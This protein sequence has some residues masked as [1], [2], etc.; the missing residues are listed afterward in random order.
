MF[1]GKEYEKQVSSLCLSLDKLDA[2]ATAAQEM[3]KSLGPSPTVPYNNNVR[4]S[5]SCPMSDAHRTHSPTSLASAA[6]SSWKCSVRCAGKTIRPRGPSGTSCP[7]AKERLHPSRCMMRSHCLSGGSSSSAAIQGPISSTPGQRV[8]RIIA[9]AAYLYPPSLASS[10]APLTKGRLCACRH[11][12][13]L[14]TGTRSNSLLTWAPLMR[15]APAPQRR[16]ALEQ[17]L[18]RD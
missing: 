12:G 17:A 18:P 11:G 9:R 3:R 15:L 1:E 6:S 10:C 4:C 2:D 16:G 13:A 14:A 5:C 7:T 8:A